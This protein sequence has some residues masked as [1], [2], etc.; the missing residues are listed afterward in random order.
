M[1][2][3]LGATFEADCNARVRCE[4]EGSRPKA[5]ARLE[6]VF[7]WC[8]LNSWRGPSSM[9]HWNLQ[10][11]WNI[12]LWFSPRREVPDHRKPVTPAA[13]RL[14]RGDD[15]PPLYEP[16]VKTLTIP[17]TI[18]DDI[19]REPSRTLLQKSGRNFEKESEAEAGE[20]FL[21]EEEKG[22]G[23]WGNKF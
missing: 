18:S 12:V 14:C 17:M 2:L 4:V 10:D 15:I 20:A 3:A 9:K 22:K 6:S 11:S 13:L 16:T 8:L 21:K 19:E 5:C 1:N 7:R 23:G